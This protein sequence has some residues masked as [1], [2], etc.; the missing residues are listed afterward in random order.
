M[1][2]RSM[3][4]QRRDQQRVLLHQTEQGYPPIEISRSIT[5]IC[6]PAWLES[7]YHAEMGR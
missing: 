1:R 7:A 5:G 2:A 4:Y 6:L 3:F